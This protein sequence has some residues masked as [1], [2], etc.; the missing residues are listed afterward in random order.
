LTKEKSKKKPA[1]KQAVTPVPAR[2][3]LYLENDPA[4]AKA[5]GYNPLLLTKIQSEG[6]VRFSDPKYIQIGSYYVACLTVL[7]L[8]SEPEDFW[9]QGL[10]DIDQAL[11]TI[12]IGA[13]DMEAVKYKLDRSIAEL[14]SRKSRS[15]EQE[16]DTENKHRLLL[17]IQADIVQNH[18][19]IKE[20]QIRL[21]VY[22]ATRAQLDRNLE[23]VKLRLRQMEFQ[24]ELLLNEQEYAFHSLTQ[25]C[26]EQ[27]KNTN[28]RHGSGVPSYAL[29]L[30]WPFNNVEL[31]DPHGIYIGDTDSGGKVCI[32]LFEKT[33]SRKSYDMVVVGTKGSGKST[34]LKLFMKNYAIRGHYVRVLDCT[35]E[36]VTLAKLLGGTVISMDGT[37]GRINC[38]EVFA[39][40]GGDNTTFAQHL[41]KLNAIYKLITPDSSDYERNEFEGYVRRLYEEKGLYNP[42]KGTHSGSLAGRPPE[43]YPTLSDLLSIIRADLYTDKTRK[44]VN[45]DLSA[46]KR[47]RLE[48]IELTIENLV[49]N[50]PELFD[51]A[52]SLPDLTSQHVVVYNVQSLAHMKDEI[53]QAMMFNILN[54]MLADV[55]RIGGR[56]KERYENG[57]AIWQ[58]PKLILIIDEAHRFIN[59]KNQM[60]LDFMQRI[61]SEG[62]KFFTS[63]FL[64][65]QSIRDFAPEAK[66][67]DPALDKLKRLFE[68]VQYKFVM[69]QDTNSTQLL[70]SVFGDGITESQLAAIPQFRTGE[71]ILLT[72]EQNLHMSVVATRKDL[73]ERFK[74][75]A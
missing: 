5:H 66:E 4:F 56:S 57:E 20:L 33:L 65:S 47:T 16:L 63:L 58:V 26:H 69:Q 28:R 44:S 3:I 67:G 23:D 46:S 34:L 59:T 38:T 1:K 55:A 2:K 18:E 22:G 68:L 6:N 74:G 45:S 70:H 54:L 72:G 41:S 14:E 42:A 19:Q 52:T 24:A 37:S 75:G 29:G 32:D 17:N 64:A 62:R 48:N 12:D 39:G 43:E 35:G 50:Y 8:P 9:L 11:V 25:S 40:I 73:V 71:A 13:M 15:S 31:L 61:V 36:F 51:S 30:S 53:F 7:E 21:F 60:V 49:N 10:L 27:H